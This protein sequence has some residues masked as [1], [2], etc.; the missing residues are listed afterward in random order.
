M[1]MSLA[2]DYVMFYGETL[3]HPLRR[4]K[5]YW[6]FSYNRAL[7]FERL[8]N[9]QAALMAAKEKSSEALNRNKNVKHIV[10]ES[11]NSSSVP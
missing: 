11:Y 4:R 5:A 9:T 6:H 8:L 7:N 1:S 3:L 10:L 2:C